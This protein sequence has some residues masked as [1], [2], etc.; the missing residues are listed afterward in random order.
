MKIS[1]LNRTIAVAT[2]VALGLGATVLSCVRA[3]SK[4]ADQAEVWLDE[5]FAHDPYDKKAKITLDVRGGHCQVTYVTPT[6]E[7]TASDTAAVE[8]EWEIENKCGSVDAPHEVRVGPFLPSPKQNRCSRVF[9]VGDHKDNPFAGGRAF[10]GDS[11][12]FKRAVKKSSVLKRDG[13]FNY[14]V[15]L[16][17]EYLGNVFFPE[18]DPIIL[19]RKGT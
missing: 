6:H 12:T 16:K 2:G 18:V 15:Y 3:E 13:Y 10:F 11:K 5:L 17:T 19:V 7:V 4:P 8:V 14:C 9:E 1:T